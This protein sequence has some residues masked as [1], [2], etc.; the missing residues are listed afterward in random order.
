MELIY[1]ESVDSTHEYLKNFVKENKDC[2]KLCIY[3]NYQINGVGSRGNSWIGKRGN[4]FFSFV[5]DK[6]FLPN[7]LLIQ[8]ASIYFSYILKIVLKNHGSNVWI[9]WPNDFYLD[10]SKI[11]GTITTLS[12]NL[13]YCG[14]GL[15]LMDV[16][17]E[18]K[19][20]DIKIDSK[21]LLIEYFEI[22][23]K[24]VEWKDI[25]KEY[26]IE[27]QESQKLFATVDGKKISLSNAILNNDGSI[28]LNGKK[29]YSLR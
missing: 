10:N 9:K 25:L 12:N 24:R 15:N 22:I 8:S 29:V 1:L 7:D 4:L 21:K 16:S 5:L 20:L 23:N 27:F 6:K 17:E 26:M 13:L 3:T 28:N 14:I 11:G 19:G 18:F 2:N